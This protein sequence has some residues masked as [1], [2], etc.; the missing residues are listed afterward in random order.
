M[1]FHILFNDN[2]LLHTQKRINKD[3]IRAYSTNEFK[4]AEYSH[5]RNSFLS[6]V[7]L[8]GKRATKLTTPLQLS[9]SR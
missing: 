1:I 6:E 4:I 5:Y 8:A 7:C 9:N 2:E 3:K